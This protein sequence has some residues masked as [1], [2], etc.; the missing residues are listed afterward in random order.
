[1]GQSSWEAVRWRA[2]IAAEIRIPLAEAV[3]ALRR[4]LVEAVRQAEGEE[5]KFALGPVELELQVEVSSN[6][7]GEAGIAF[8]LVAIGGRASRTDTAT[9]TIRLNLAPVTVTGPI[10][11]RSHVE[12]RP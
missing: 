3:R 7:E 9:H 11:I 5:I 12:E 4:E 10:E 2:S 8:W 6:T 1:V